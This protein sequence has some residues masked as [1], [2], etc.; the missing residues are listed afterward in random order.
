[1]EIQHKPQ[2]TAWQKNMISVKH[3]FHKS[4]F[5]KFG[6]T[7]Q[8]DWRLALLCFVGGLIAVVAIDGLLFVSLSKESKAEST[9]GTTVTLEKEEILE[10]VK[11]VREGDAESAVIPASVRIDPAQ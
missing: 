11:T 8:K 9:S 10:A 6:E 4:N 3:S 2:A 7:P 5:A 1:M